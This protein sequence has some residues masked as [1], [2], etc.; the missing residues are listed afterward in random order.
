MK[1]TYIVGKVFT[2]LRFIFQ[3]VTFIFNTIFP[4]LLET[5]CAGR[6]KLCCSVGA[7]HVRCVAARR[8]QQYGV[9]EVNPSG[10]AKRWIFES[11]KSGL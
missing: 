5:L 10:A 1:F 3:R 9:L 8:R 2:K 4:P 7:L 6:I 11:V